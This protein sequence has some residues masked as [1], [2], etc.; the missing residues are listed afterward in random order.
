[1]FVTTICFSQKETNDPMIDAYM[2]NN[3]KTID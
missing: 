3:K 2:K 1:M